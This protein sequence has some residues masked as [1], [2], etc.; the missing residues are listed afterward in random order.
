MD[1]FLEPI[2]N[3]RTVDK[4]LK[5]AVFAFAIYLIT[6]LLADFPTTLY[7]LVESQEFY[8]FEGFFLF[9]NF[10]SILTLVA[11]YLTL[12]ASQEQKDE[13]LE[14]FIQKRI[15]SIFC[16]FYLLQF[17]IVQEAIELRPINIKSI[18]SSIKEFIP[19]DWTM[20]QWSFESIFIGEFFEY[21]DVLELIISVI[22]A[23]SFFIAILSFAFYLQKNWKVFEFRVDLSH[24][25]QGFNSSKSKLGV[26]ILI[27]PFL[28]FGNAK[29]QDND[30]F[31]LTT[32]VEFIQD[33]LV[34]FQGKLPKNDS[35]LGGSE[36]IE[37]RK[38]QAQLVYKEIVAK[39]RWI[40]DDKLSIWSP[41]VKELRVEVLEWLDLWKGILRELSLN[42]YS[43]K[44][45]IFELQ[46]K[47]KEVSN[48]AINRAPK[49]AADYTKSFWADEFVS[50]LTY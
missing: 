25:F 23:T 4:K 42:G 45:S 27:L 48:L 34:S 28:I 36:V 29:I 31:S 26:V 35:G 46:Q 7:F 41:D 3:L 10:L 47:Y 20:I 17:Y 16:L 21:D 11:I 6:R 24:F 14:S 38:V 9:D 22:S 1:N 49:L 37:Q 39:E 5:I 15:L 12:K 43:E 50:L 8:N 30:F 2:R 33:D 40:A 44:E 13:N 32:T 18:P 19:I